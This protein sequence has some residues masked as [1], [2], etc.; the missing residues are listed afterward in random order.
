MPLTLYTDGGVVQKNPSPFAG[1][2]AY[3]IVD[4]NGT[5]LEEVSGL[6]YPKTLENEKRGLITS[7]GLLVTNN[8]TEM[9]AL[10]MGLTRIPPQEP[11][12][13][14]CTDSKVTIGRAFQGQTWKNIPPWMTDLY[15]NLRAQL[16]HWNKYQA[17]LLQGHP[18]KKELDAHIG[19]SGRPVSIHNVRCDELCH[20]RG[21][22][23]FEKWQK[24]RMS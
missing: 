22:E 17:I 21:A 20:Q 1:T 10:L 24:E 3:V 14:I 18:N 11:R 6:L 16:P 8:Q 15:K 19:T 5:V 12:V 7:G 23:Y 13:V 2:W 4:H 9:L